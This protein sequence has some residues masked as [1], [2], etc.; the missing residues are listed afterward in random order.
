MNFIRYA[1]VAKAIVIDTDDPTAL[2]RI[3]VR[4]PEIHGFKDK[5]SYGPLSN[6]VINNAW[7]KD[8]DLP[9]ASVCYPFGSTT[10]PEINQVVWVAFV[11]G[12]AQYPVILGWAGYEYVMNEEILHIN[13]S[14]Y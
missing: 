1:G 7:T 2:G 4:I 8:E 11:N 5:A 12:N 10:T 14:G 9:W 3:K 13:N 6:S